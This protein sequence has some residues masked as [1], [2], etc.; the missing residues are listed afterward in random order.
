M[1]GVAVLGSTGTV[2]R[3]TLEVLSLHPERFR[4]VALAARIPALAGTA[5]MSRTSDI[6]RMNRKPNRVSPLMV[7]PPVVSLP[8]IDRST[9]KC[10]VAGILL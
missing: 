2:G 6:Q 9:R 10:W 4:V 5:I 1:I 3:N 7:V 8:Y